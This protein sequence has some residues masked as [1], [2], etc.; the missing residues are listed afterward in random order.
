MRAGPVFRRFMTSHSPATTA[1]FTALANMPHVTCAVL[2]AGWEAVS[3]VGEESK[4]PRQNPGRAMI[5]SVA[6]LLVWF[7]G[8][9]M[10]FQGISSQKVLL[11][12]GGDVLAYAGS[13]LAPGLAGRILLPLAVLIAV[14]GTT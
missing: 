12:H 3:V 7:T 9:I 6:F 2:Y 11:S 4:E 14:I 1:A 13:V 8:L 5:G 10:V